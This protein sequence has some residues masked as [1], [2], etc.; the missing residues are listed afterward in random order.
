MHLLVSSGQFGELRLTQGMATKTQAISREA[1]QGDSWTGILPA[2]GLQQGGRSSM[3]FL[4][5]LSHRTR[6]GDTMVTQPEA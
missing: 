2:A 1:A 5:H 3:F 4:I 6:E